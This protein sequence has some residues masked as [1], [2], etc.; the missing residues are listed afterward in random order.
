MSPGE[1]GAKNHVYTHAQNNGN[2]ED[3]DSQPVKYTDW[4]L[5]KQALH[6][7]MEVH[8]DLMVHRMVHQWGLMVHP[9]SWIEWILGKLADGIKI[10]K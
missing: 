1:T 2:S 7:L 9:L 8:W 10:R 4:E 3:S 6:L 5:K